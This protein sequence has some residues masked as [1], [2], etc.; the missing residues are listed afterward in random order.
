MRVWETRVAAQVFGI[1][2]SRFLELTRRLN[3]PHLSRLDG[4]RGTPKYWP[5]TSM[6][7][8][9]NLRGGNWTTTP[10]FKKGGYIS[11]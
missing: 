8:V 6:E 7:K 4:V 2:T 10:S 5:E 1:S 3:L 9:S 11:I